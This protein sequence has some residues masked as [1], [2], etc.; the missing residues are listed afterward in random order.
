MVLR[1]LYNAIWAHALKLFR[2][3]AI[4]D[5]D[6]TLRR[7][8]HLHAFIRPF[9]VEP[10]AEQAPELPPVLC[11]LSLI[12][13]RHVMA[14]ISC[15]PPDMLEFGRRGPQ[16]PRDWPRV[17]PPPPPMFNACSPAAL[18]AKAAARYTGFAMQTQRDHSY[19]YQ[20]GVPRDLPD[21]PMAGS[22]RR[23]PFETPS[24]L[25]RPDNRERA[26]RQWQVHS[27]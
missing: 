9:R 22:L 20:H 10:E 2:R 8:P 24:E 27:G 7:N 19:F 18:R 26:L 15:F 3:Q 4:A 23:F 17:S 14:E 5:H 16:H 12:A 1:F 13:V 11:R 21:R 25:Q 6:D